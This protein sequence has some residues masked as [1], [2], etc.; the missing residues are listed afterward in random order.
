MTDT[1]E[2]IL[3]RLLAI[4][5]SL[6]GIAYAA[7]NDINIAE[8]QLPAAIVL[9]GEEEVDDDHLRR[10]VPAL[11]S[12]RVHMTPLVSLWVSERTPDVG[13]ALNALR[14]ALI[15]AVL[16]DTT[17]ATLAG[18]GGGRSSGAVRY[19]GCAPG[20]MEGRAVIGNM[21]PRFRISYVLDPS[22]L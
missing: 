6:D 9:D 18:E 19:L 1:R 20:L 11:A 15:R 5:G 21:I 13:G 4:A 7:R 12:M 10:N 3:V 2:A 17:L 16:S 14:A 8:E 22:E